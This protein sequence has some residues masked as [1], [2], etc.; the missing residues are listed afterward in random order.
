[1][2]RNNIYIYICV[3]YIKSS[4]W[5][6]GARKKRKP[7]GSIRKHRTGRALLSKSLLGRAPQPLAARNRCSG[8]P[9]CHLALEITARARF[10]CSAAPANAGQALA[11]AA[12]APASVVGFDNVFA[13]P[14]ESLPKSL[15][16]SL[17]F[18]LCIAWRCVLRDFTG[19]V[20]CHMRI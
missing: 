10:W 3:L 6:G 18:G 16:E 9:L 5:V 7:L 11:L 12:A 13:F 2:Y 19:T 15:S 8:V 20:R 1:M 14:A 17:C 4:A